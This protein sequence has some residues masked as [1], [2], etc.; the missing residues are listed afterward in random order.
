MRIMIL[1]GILVFVTATAF[2]EFSTYSGMIRSIKDH[3]IVLIERG[4]ERTLEYSKDA[5]CYLNGMQVS[6]GRIRPNSKVRI[7]CPTNG[8]C[9]RIIVDQGPQ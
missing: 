6:C 9:V 4:S 3:N 5:A 2:A 1:V 8:A 7:D